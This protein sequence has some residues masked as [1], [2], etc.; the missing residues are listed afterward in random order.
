MFF[1]TIAALFGGT[2]LEKNYGEKQ[3]EKITL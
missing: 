3:W 2:P 1:G